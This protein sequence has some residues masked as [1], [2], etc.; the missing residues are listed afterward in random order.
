MVPQP[1]PP[2]A[3]AGEG[4]TPEERS[5]ERATTRARFRGMV[6]KHGIRHG[7]AGGL[8]GDSPPFRILMDAK[9]TRRSRRR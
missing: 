6:E 3:H 7:A 2:G 5:K 8:L 9:Q 1:P 4:K